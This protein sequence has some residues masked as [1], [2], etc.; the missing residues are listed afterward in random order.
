[1]PLDDQSKEALANLIDITKGKRL[2]WRSHNNAFT[3]EVDDVAISITQEPADQTG[4]LMWVFSVKSNNG[5]DLWKTTI[6]AHDPD[7]LLL[8]R[9]YDIAK[10]STIQRL[11]DRLKTLD[12]PSR[13]V[14]SATVSETGATPPPLPSKPT[15]KQMASVFHSIEGTWDLDYTTGK[16]RATITSSGDYFVEGE[17][18]KYEGMPKFRLLLI[19]C[20]SDLSKIEIVKEFLD[21]RRHDTEVL[22]LKTNVL[23][24]E[25]TS[26]KRKIKYV[27]VAK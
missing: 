21:G 1:M 8:E 26:R 7:H 14:P 17:R 19:A 24:G 2:S 5:S 18:T 6:P 10:N 9:A 27:R 13:P 16:E 20:N 4:E 23:E 11:F 25:S 3:C 12:V 15:F 22:N